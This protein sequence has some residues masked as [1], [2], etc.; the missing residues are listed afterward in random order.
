MKELFQDEAGRRFR[1]ANK[2]SESEM[3]TGSRGGQNEGEEVFY[4]RW[5]GHWRMKGGG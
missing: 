1:K 4:E 2:K 3:W 5:D